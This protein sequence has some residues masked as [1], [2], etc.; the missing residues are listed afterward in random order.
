[1]FCLIRIIINPQNKKIK[2]SFDIFNECLTF[3]PI[4]CTLKSSKK[5]RIFT[6]RIYT[7]NNEFIYWYDVF[8]IDY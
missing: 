6:A 7:Q 8:Q 3:I 5:L 2:Y 4:D 1:M